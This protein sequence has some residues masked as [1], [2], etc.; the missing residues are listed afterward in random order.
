M[1]LLISRSICGYEVWLAIRR[2]DTKRPFIAWLWTIA[3]NKARDRAR[4]AAFR[5]LMFGSASFE[6]S[7]ALAQSDPT[8]PADEGVIERQVMVVL[9]QAIARLPARLKEALLLTAF[10][11]WSQQEA[12]HILRV[13]TKTIETLVY[14]ARKILERTLEP[15]LKPKR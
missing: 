2:N 9:G 10:D 8:M 14:R 5:R 7:G 6:E 15:N 1:A 4:R 11:G 12:G 3:I 13:S